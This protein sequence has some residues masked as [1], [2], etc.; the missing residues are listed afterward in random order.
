M[1]INTIFEIKIS[2]SKLYFFD[3]RNRNFIDKKFDKLH[4]K[5]KIK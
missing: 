3:Q 1:L 2:I 5:N 4:A